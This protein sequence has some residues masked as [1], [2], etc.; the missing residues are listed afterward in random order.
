MSEYK[1]TY[2]NGRGR[3]EITRLILTAAGQKF[4][5]ER[6]E[7]TEWPSHKAGTYIVKSRIPD[8]LVYIY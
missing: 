1:L 7:F 3:A 6:F 8:L 5:D 2:F 4:T